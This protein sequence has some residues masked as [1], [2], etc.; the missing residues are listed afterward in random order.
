MR[1]SETDIRPEKLMKVVKVFINY[2]RKILLKNKKKFVKV[3]CPACQSKKE[4]FFLKKNG[5]RY[6]TCVNCLTSYM[7]PR[8]TAKI[9]EHFYKNSKNSMHFRSPITFFS[10]KYFLIFSFFDKISK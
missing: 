7:N 3:F 5:F 6:S 1:F 4:K 9:L 2:D 10:P 8:P